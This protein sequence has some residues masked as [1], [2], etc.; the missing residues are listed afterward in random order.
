MPCT[1]RTSRSRPRWC[2]HMG[3]TRSP[4]KPYIGDVC[5]SH[6]ALVNGVT[7]AQSQ[8]VPGQMGLF[9][10]RRLS[11]GHQL[12]Y[13][14]TKP[15]NGLADMAYSIVFNGEVIVDASDATRASAARYV[16]A[17]PLWR[18]EYQLSDRCRLTPNCAIVIYDDNVVVIET[19]R[20][21]AK[22]AE[23]LCNYG[24]VYWSEPQLRRQ[25]QAVS[26]SYY[27]GR[28]AQRRPR[29]P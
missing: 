24:H 29:R 18:S 13:A 4:T 1:R 19:T 12:R 16:N 25:L 8:V 10:A 27:L 28:Q 3:C 6:L 15:A 14:G 17:P 26:H 2:K 9:A 7:V 11:R 23:L 20:K 5:H 22:G 21:V